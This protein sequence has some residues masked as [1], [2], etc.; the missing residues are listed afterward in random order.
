M[1]RYD[2]GPDKLKAYKIAQDACHEVFSIHLR[3][4]PTDP[5]IPHYC[6]GLPE[7]EDRTYI[8]MPNDDYKKL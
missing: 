4:L 1:D 5:D 3:L 8:Q 6:Y 2:P 7:F